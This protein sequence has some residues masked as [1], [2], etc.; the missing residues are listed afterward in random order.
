ML[1]VVAHHADQPHPERHGWVPPLVD[2]PPGT[3]PHVAN[4][5]Q[6]VFTHDKL[7][8]DINYWPAEGEGAR[9]NQPRPTGADAT[10]PPAASSTSCRTEA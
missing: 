8:T 4:V 7:W 1:K 9:F 2:H 6:V 3:F 5:V 10:P